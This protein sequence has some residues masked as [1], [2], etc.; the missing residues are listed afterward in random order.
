MIKNNDTLNVCIC[1]KTFEILCSEI[2]FLM[3]LYC[4]D[5]KKRAL[6]LTHD[7][8]SHRQTSGTD[9][10]IKDLSQFYLR[11]IWHGKVIAMGN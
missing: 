8:P 6:N 7:G 2:T 5:T 11:L 4:D 3:D 9:P 1:E 10:P